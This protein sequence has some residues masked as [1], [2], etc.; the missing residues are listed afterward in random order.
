MKY[1]CGIVLM[2]ALAFGSSQMKVTVSNCTKSTDEAHLTSLTLSPPSPE[3]VNT[4]W[5]VVG[6]GE[7]EAD[8]TQGTFTAEAKLA[9]IPIFSQK[10]DICKPDKITLPL[11]YGFIYFGG[12]KCP[13]NKGEN[14]AVPVT[15]YVSSTAPDDTIKVSV[16]AEDT[17]TKHQIF[18]VNVVVDIE[19][20]TDV[21]MVN[22]E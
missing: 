4:N 14:L 16:T 7:S 6:T 18:C 19:K 5:T 21:I 3:K 22:N 2:V 17:K 10:G 13:L 8:I 11:G 1:F 9:G 12:V 20:E 15:S